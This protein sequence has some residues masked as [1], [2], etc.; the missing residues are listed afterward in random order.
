MPYMLI[1][2]GVEHGHIDLCTT[3]YDVNDLCTTIYDLTDL[4]TTCV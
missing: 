1:A 4:C 2:M 3:V